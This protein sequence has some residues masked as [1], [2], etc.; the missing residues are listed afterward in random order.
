M[1]IDS[2]GKYGEFLCGPIEYKIMTDESIPQETDLVTMSGDVLTFAPQL[3]DQLGPQ[4]L[5]LIGFLPNYSGVVQAE[6]FTVIVEAC[7]ADLVALPA[8]EALTD[9]EKQWSD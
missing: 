1:D 9:I 6:V 4:N 5:V 2:Q 7:I 8:Q 3:D